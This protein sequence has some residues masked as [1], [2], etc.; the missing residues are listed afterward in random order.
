MNYSGPQVP[1]CADRC[2]PPTQFNR[3]GAW[4]VRCA[5][6][7]A[8]GCRQHRKRDVSGPRR[9]IRLRAQIASYRGAAA[10]FRD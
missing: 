5:R 10:A 8:R 9:A 4:P 3:R 1:L 2:H 6:S 7:G